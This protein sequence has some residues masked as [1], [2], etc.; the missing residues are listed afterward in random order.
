MT[1]SPEIIIRR[2]QAGDAAQWKVLWQ[3]YLKFCGAD[4]ADDITELTWQ[5]ILDPTSPI[6]AWVG[7]TGTQRAGFAV[8]VEHAGTWT[9]TP[10]C[11]LDDL[12]VGEAYRGR[13]VGRALLSSLAAHANEAGW[14]RLYWHTKND[15]AVARRLYDSFVEADTLVRYRLLF[16]SDNVQSL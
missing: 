11:Y 6:H 12:F 13:G 4:L 7:V 5:R 15:N 8:C 9:R 16:D 14:S 2:A 1:S 10:I 3:S